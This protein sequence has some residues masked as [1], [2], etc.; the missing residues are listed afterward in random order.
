MSISLTEST[1]TWHLRACK[2]GF[3][4]WRKQEILTK[5]VDFK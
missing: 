1:V 5:Q 3:S 2:L 4:F